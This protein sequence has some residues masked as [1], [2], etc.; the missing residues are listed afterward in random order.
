MYQI[1]PES[2]KTFI[3]DSK[4][5]LPRFQRKQTW[6]DKKNF[7]LCISV[8]NNFPIGAVVI[9]Q[10]EDHKKWLLDGRQ[11]R[12]AIQ[13]MIKNPEVIYDW[14]KKFLKLKNNDHPDEVEEKY[15]K[16]IEE[17]LGDDD[18]SS[19][20]ISEQETA[21]E[22]QYDDEQIE[23]QETE[24][25]YEQSTVTQKKDL[26][27]RLILSCHNKNALGSNLSKRFDFDTYVKD[28]DYIEFNGQGKTI[29]SQKLRSWLQTLE[30]YCEDNEISY[31]PNQEDFIEYLKKYSINNQAK[32]TALI[33]KKW[34][35]I[36]DA[37][38]LIDKVT[39]L[40]QSV[41]IGIIELSDIDSYEAQTIFKI[42]NTAGSPL[43]AAEILS[44]KPSWNKEIKNPSLELKDQVKK[45]YQEMEIQATNCVKWDFPATLLSRLELPFVFPKL[46]YSDS[47]QFEKAITLGFKL[48]SAEYI[49]GISKNHVSMLSD[50]NSIN[51][52]QDPE[53]M[54]ADLNLMG[55]VLSADNFYKYMQ[56]WKINIMDLMSDA[57]AINFVAITYK[58]WLRKEKPVGNSATTNKFIKNSRVLFDS[59]V[60]EYITRQWRGSS[61]SRVGENLK[62]FSAK[63]DLYEPI[64]KEKWALLLEEIIEKHEVLGT[65][66]KQDG[67]D[68]TVMPPLLYY[69]YILDE[70]Q[71]PMGL[72]VTIE[73]DH[74]IPRALFES[75]HVEN[76]SIIT[77]NLF[78]LCLLP[79][80]ENI[81]KRDKRL[82]EITD[83]WLI[84]EVEKYTGIN[85]KDFTKYSDIQN[86]QALK[87][88]RKSKLLE[89]LIN[90]RNNY[91]IN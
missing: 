54:L 23:S 58:D 38:D 44:A 47:K 67:I 10:D 78:N 60:F 1:R 39:D 28:L 43:T 42:I 83:T 12:N 49:G 16:A 85:R 30:R 57:I 74:I 9:S 51:W 45:L 80:K 15:T 81:T 6:D 63:S 34:E 53:K 69:F 21:S 48:M 71:G 76:K 8:F 70:K 87:A 66:A 46:A 17:Y 7:Q 25:D 36:S 24:A 56:S 86:I 14:G 82:L 40:L 79:K 91:L 84:D 19:K 62:N 73:K 31:P 2:I 37:I 89:V 68:N 29:N 3:E 90:K 65:K 32:L 50:A 11:R 4:T 5:R 26:L 72:D 75:S 22:E 55:K 13:N 18:D 77:N 52:E 27:L 64:S 20:Q 88:E 61:D 41:K 35:K 59:L 33:A